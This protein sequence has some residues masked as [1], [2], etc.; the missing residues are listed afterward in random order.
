VTTPAEFRMRLSGLL[1][2]AVVRDVSVSGVR[3][4]TA[5]PLPLL[6]QMQVVLLLPTDGHA[7]EVVCSGAVVRCVRES[8]ARAAADSMYESAIFFTAIEDGD[9]SALQEYVSTLHRAGKVA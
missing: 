2:T 3:C 7:R 6:S 8:A 5:R 1:D 4:S 9:R